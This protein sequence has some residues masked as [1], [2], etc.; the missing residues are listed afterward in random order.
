VYTYN[1]NGAEIAQQF[2]DTIA[3]V[4]FQTTLE[5]RPLGVVIANGIADGI[6]VR[7]FTRQC[8]GQGNAWPRNSEPCG[9]DKHNAY[10]W[11]Q[12]DSRTCGM[13]A[14]E[15]LLGHVE[16]TDD[17]VRITYGTGQPTTR[18]ANPLD[19]IED[20]D[21][22]I[23]DDDKAFYAEQQGRGF[24]ELDADINQQIDEDIEGALAEHF[25]RQ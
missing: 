7:S 13:L 19:H 12:T 11:E 17:F 1:D 2:A 18:A 6:I 25:A 24:Y 21:K 3:S 20:S 23:S 22:R 4:E 9:E 16:I 15:S 5:S 8:D 10:G 14:R